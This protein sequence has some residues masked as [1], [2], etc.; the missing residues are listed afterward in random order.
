MS[1]IKLAGNSFRTT[2]PE[3]QTKSLRHKKW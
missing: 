3:C 1:D 2:S